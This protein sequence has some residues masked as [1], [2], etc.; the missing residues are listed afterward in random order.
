[1]LVFVI[2]GNLT[3]VRFP[4]TWNVVIDIVFLFVPEGNLACARF[5]LASCGKYACLHAR[6]KSSMC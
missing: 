2:E 1:M 6:S 3:W 4:S 5:I